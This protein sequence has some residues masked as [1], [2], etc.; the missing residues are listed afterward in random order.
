VCQM[1]WIAD[2]S[3]SR[4]CPAAVAGLALAGC[5]A[6]H[7]ASRKD[8]IARG[9]A[10]CA[11]A[12]SAVRSVPPPSGQSSAS[13]ARYYRRVTPIV[14]TEVRELRG[15]PRPAQ[16]R[17]LMSRYVRAIASSAA[18]YQVLAAAAQRGDRGALARASAALRSNPAASLA[19]R[20]GIADCAASPGTAAS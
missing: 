3:S 12:A 1:R 8:V 15:L 7:A 14:E 6:S 13:L 9:D 4:A 2:L 17:V 11:T 16:D 20:Y 19:A 10:I 5:G 18:Q